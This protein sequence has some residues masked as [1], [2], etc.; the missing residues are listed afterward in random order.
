MRGSQLA[1][2]KRVDKLAAVHKRLREQV[3]ASSLFDC[4]QLDR[5]L[6]SAW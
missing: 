5:K 1:N 6:E 3:A 2:P 4:L